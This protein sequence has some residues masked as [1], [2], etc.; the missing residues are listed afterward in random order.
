MPE[1]VAKLLAVKA[2]MPSVMVS[3]G[4]NCW[5]RYQL[6]PFMIS[7]AMDIVQSDTNYSGITEGWSIGQNLDKYGKKYDPHNW[8]GGL[9]TISNIHLVAGVPS[10]H[11]CE[12]NMTYNPLK[13]E[14]F[15]DPYEIKNGWLTI[16]DKPGYGVELIDNIEKI[17]PFVP[18]FYAK[19]NPKMEGTGLPLW[20]S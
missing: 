2:A 1:I 11:M 10:G 6:E 15:K 14:I 19:P 16:P 13:W 9:T 7:G 4:E 5:N 3:G 12:T 18:G 8:V 20:W 17:F